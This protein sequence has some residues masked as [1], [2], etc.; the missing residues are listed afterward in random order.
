MN[1]LDFILLGIIAT[2]T[3][4]GLL[5]GPL[6]QIYRISSVALS[7]TGAFLL[8]NLLSSILNGIFSPKVSNILG[9]AIAFSVILIITYAI[10]NLFRRFLTKRRFGMSGRIVGGGISFIKTV[11]T[12]CIIIAGVS[13]WGNDQTEKTIGNS[14]IANNIDKGTK[15]VISRLPQNVKDTSIIEK[16]DSDKKQN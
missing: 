5:T 14:L 9:Y 7:V 12:C 16:K 3:L 6:W 11:L 10:G 2:G 1:W 15:A 13:F 4:F 8:H